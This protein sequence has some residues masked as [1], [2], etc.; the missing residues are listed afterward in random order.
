MSFEL[1]HGI[2][3]R[4][5]VLSVHLVYFGQEI[6]FDGK[7]SGKQNVDECDDETRNK[8]ERSSSGAFDDENG[9]NGSQYVNDSR[10]HHGE[11]DLVRFNTYQRIV[12]W[13]LV[14]RGSYV[15]KTMIMNY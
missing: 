4:H 6:F 14:N 15:G 9:Q 10:P 2:G 1:I 7:T 5:I 12:G 11:R 3:E 13:L 8:Y